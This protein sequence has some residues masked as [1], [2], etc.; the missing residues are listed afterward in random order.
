MYSRTYPICV[1]LSLKEKKNNQ[2]KNRVDYVEQVE[3]ILAATHAK[4][5]RLFRRAQDVCVS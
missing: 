2:K 1:S 4:G 3:E 5:A